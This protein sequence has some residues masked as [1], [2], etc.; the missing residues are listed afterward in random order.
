LEAQAGLLEA[1][2]A[3][4]V[5]GHRREALAAHL[6]HLLSRPVHEPI[7]RPTPVAL[8]PMAF[9]PDELLVLAQESQPELLA[10]KFSA[11]RAEASWKLA[12]RELVPDLET[13]LELR[14]PAMGPIGPWDLTLAVV[15]PFWFWTKARY[16]VRGALY[17]KESAQAA[18]RAMQNAVARRVHEHWHQAVAAFRTATLSRDGLIPLG[19]Q[20]VAS[21]LAAY[22]GGRE[23]FVAV[24]NTLQ[25][26]AERKRAYYQALVEF[27]QHLIML[28]QAVGVPL[29]PEFG[30]PSGRTS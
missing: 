15:L 13:M 24:L 1:E 7:G 20:A 16:G 18:Y 30:E 17:D 10:F 11:E 23:P 12:K 6:N 19:R 2:N 26:L 29:R 22:Q 21:G 3:L 4:E 9:S 14:D 8:A 25:S 28:E 5:L 27:E